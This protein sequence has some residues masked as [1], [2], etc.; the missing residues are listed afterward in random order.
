MQYKKVQKSSWNEPYSSSSSV[1][2]VRSDTCFGT[3]ERQATHFGGWMPF[4]L[5]NQQCQQLRESMQSRVCVT[6][7]R[8]SV[9]LSHH[10]PA[11]LRCGGFAAVRP[12]GTRCRSIAA[13]RSAATPGHR[14]MRAVSGVHGW[15]I[16]SRTVT[17]PKAKLKVQGDV[18]FFM[19]W[20]CCSK[21]LA[22]STSCARLTVEK[23]SWARSI[24][25]ENC[26]DHTATTK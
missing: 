10:S 13:R 22:L 15:R 18:L 21:S 2:S 16:G 25:R 24:L 7:G 11:A 19:S 6:V 3:S 8:P 14:Q 26:N 12:A 23:C 20:C 5:A 1:P 4:Q 9:R 17:C